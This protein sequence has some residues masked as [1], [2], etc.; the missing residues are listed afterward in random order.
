MQDSSEKVNPE[1]HHIH[2]GLFW[3]ARCAPPVLSGC[4]SDPKDS[5]KNSGDS[6]GAETLGDFADTQ[7]F[8]GPV[9]PAL[10]CF[11]LA[12]PVS[13]SV[14]FCDSVAL[15]LARRFLFLLVFLFQ[16]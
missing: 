13:L 4:D 2:F 15:F 7:L 5:R 11:C 10:F 1:R 9:L 6:R 8:S 3:V 16:K 14:V 12:L